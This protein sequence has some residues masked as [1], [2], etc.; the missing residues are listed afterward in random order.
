MDC[1]ICKTRIR[2]DSKKAGKCVVCGTP[3]KEEPKK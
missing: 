2:S 3:V 1:P